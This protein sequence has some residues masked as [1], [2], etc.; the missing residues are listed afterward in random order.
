[1]VEVTS[2]SSPTF[3]GIGVPRAGTT[4]LRALLSEHPAV[5]VPTRR[6][7]ICFFDLYFD[8]GLGWYQKFFPS[9][10]EAARYRAIG[11]ITPFYLYGPDCP[12]RIARQGVEKLVLVLRNPVERAWSYYAHMMH[13]GAFRGSF[14]EF[15][16]EPRFA[17]IEH[18]YYAKYLRRY[19]KYFGMEQILVLLFEDAVR[20]TLGT[21]E[22]I[23]GF[24]GIDP[25]GFPTA[26]GSRAV[27]S[28][29]LPRARRIYSVAF[30]V[31]RVLRRWDLDFV[32]NAAKRL[33]IKEMFGTGGTLPPMS[34]E[35]ATRL[36]EGYRADIS[37][38]EQLLGISLARWQQDPPR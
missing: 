38:L 21:K 4:W 23:A 28:S 7:E 12:E 29:F 1:M 30:G 26:S 16:A 18:G 35:L 34:Q 5:F 36:R 24:L 31:S 14:D 13:N 25:N 17:A 3:L 10:S 6:Q 9:A 37:D 33:G 11:E 15:L 19:L 32:V 22:R 2:V 20:D 27:N 8:R